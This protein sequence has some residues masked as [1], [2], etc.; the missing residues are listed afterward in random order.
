MCINRFNK[1]VGVDH[2][3]LNPSYA[4]DKR[5]LHRENFAVLPP[6][7]SDNNACPSLTP[8]SPHQKRR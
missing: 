8:D 6:D 1:P 7:N 2:L 4:P 5:P 3:A